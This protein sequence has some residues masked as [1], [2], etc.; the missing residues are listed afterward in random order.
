MKT[1]ATYSVHG[2]AFKTLLEAALRA[3]GLTGSAPFSGG[4]SESFFD[5]FDW[6]LYKE[7]LQCRRRGEAFELSRLDGEGKPLSAKPRRPAHAKFAKDFPQ[8]PFREALAGIC[9]LRALIEVCS[10]RRSF[11]ETK[12]LD[13][14]EKT[15]AKVRYE[16]VF[17]DGEERGELV[18][19]LSV[20]AMKGY[21]EEAEALCRELDARGLPRLFA[22]HDELRLALGAS[23]RSPDDYS[24]SFQA[25]VKRGM[26]CREAA[27]SILLKLMETMSRNVGGVVNDTD[28]EFLHDFRVASRRIRSA[29]SQIK[30]VFPEEDALRMKRDFASI[31]KLTNK[32]RDLDVL[33]LARQD[34][35][36]A[37]PEE[38]RP[39]LASFFKSLEARRA[40]EF[41]KLS[42]E[43]SAPGRAKTLR[44]WIEY[45]ESSASL[46]RQANSSRQ[47]E[48]LAGLFI[49]K[50]L[51]RVL[52][53]ADRLDERSPDVEMHALRI[54]CKKLR[55]LLE[56]FGPLFESRGVDKLLGRLKRLQ[57]F[58]GGLNDLSVQQRFLSE[59]LSRL[60]LKDQGSI[61]PAAALGAL[62]AKLYES[63]RK[64]KGSFS[65]VFDKFLDSEEFGELQTVF[66]SKSKDRGSE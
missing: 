39:G 1:I 3:S 23:G 60:P 12:L 55:Y 13:A 30:G 61:L 46:P 62:I 24:S 11:V 54:E 8:G 59:S 28:V 52:K 58:L 5:T 32:L 64:L 2:E 47:V 14:S 26:S 50:R 36:E 45:L 18:S 57:D 29:V 51:K 43:L 9:Q 53:S 25:P 48:R 17:A 31:G 38:L 20:V 27:S 42:A 16:R 56:F 41:A 22:D 49:L 66:K 34:C 44:R 10:V 35:E 4:C 63:R 33:L 19:F 6:R 21:R 7:G 37:V 40:A 65:K 15:V